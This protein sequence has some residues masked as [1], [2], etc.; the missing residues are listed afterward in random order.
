MTVHDRY[1]RRALLAGVSTT[2]TFLAGC[3]GPGEQ[4]PGDDPGEAERENPATE[5]NDS[6]GATNGSDNG[7]DAG[8]EEATANESAGDGATGGWESTERIE[9]E[10]HASGWQGTSPAPIEGETNPTLELFTG[11]EYTVVWENSDNAPHNF[12]F[13]DEDHDAVAATDIIESE[14]E[15]TTLSVE[16]TE[17]IDRYV[18]EQHPNDMHGDVTFREE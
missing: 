17:E 9:L 4:R 2:A 10:A 18:C 8:D 15:S 5:E 7:T 6:E 11:Q 13:W 3:G 12:A 14:G 16:V 1:S